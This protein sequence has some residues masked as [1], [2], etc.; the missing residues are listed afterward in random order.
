MNDT[1]ITAEKVIE[2][3]FEGSPYTPASAITDADI[4][5]A[6][7]RYITPIVG[8]DLM[9]ALAN[10]SYPTLLNEY[11]TPALAECVRIECNLITAPTTRRERL[12]ARA[13][14]KIL[15]DHLNDNS[16]SYSDYSSSDNVLNRCSCDGG[17]VQIL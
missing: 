12:R 14:L 2:I 15:S 3:A 16:A 9:A 4:I 11:V 6:Q 10:G 5:A 17:F 13:M 1:L 8:E 7:Q